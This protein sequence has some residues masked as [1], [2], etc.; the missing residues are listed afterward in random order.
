MQGRVGL[1]FRGL[2]IGVQELGGLDWRPWRGAPGRE[3]ESNP[4]A[5]GRPPGGGWVL[6]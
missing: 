3:R 4:R 2:G 1:G 6:E 5:R